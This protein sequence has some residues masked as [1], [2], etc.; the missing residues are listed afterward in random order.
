MGVPVIGGNVGGVPETMQADVTGLLV[1]PRDPAALA[2]A[3]ERLLADPGLRRS[4]GRAGRDW[5]RGQ[6][7]FS[8]ETAASQVEQAY[9][10]WLAELGAR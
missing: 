7:L 4:M 8:A 1:P 10:R 2:A 6:G 3:L 9:S 5:I